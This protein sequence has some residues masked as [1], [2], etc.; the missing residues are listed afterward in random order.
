MDPYT[1]GELAEIVRRAAVEAG[2][3]IEPGAAEL[4]GFYAEGSPGR[5]LTIFGRMCQVH[6]TGAR[7][8]HPPRGRAQGV[9]G[10][11]VWVRM[12][13]NPRGLCKVL[14]RSGLPNSL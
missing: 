12:V 10:V 4:I 2:L 1:A 7:R 8:H 13:A 9:E 3:K 6:G 11:G 14:V 5:A